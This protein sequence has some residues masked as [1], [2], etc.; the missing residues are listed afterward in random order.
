MY[1]QTQR[2]RECILGSRLYEDFL[3]VDSF[4]EIARVAGGVLV[5]RAVIRQ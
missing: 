1:A 3:Q 4:E 5:L 2:K